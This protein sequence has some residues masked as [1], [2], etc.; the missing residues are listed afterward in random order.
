MVQVDDHSMNLYLE[1][2]SSAMGEAWTTPAPPAKAVQQPQVKELQQAKEAKPA[3]F[4]FPAMPSF[5]K[6]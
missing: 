6:N 3:G 5:L 2:L 1:A 4:K